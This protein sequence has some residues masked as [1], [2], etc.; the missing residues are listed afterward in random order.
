MIRW[1]PTQRRRV[2]AALSRHPVNSSRCAKAARAILPIAQQVDGTAHAR[3][4]KP[5]DGALYVQPKDLNVR[6]FHHVTVAVEAYHVD[7]LTG[8]PGH[9]QVT[10][11]EHFYENPEGHSIRPVAADEWGQL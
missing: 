3:L 6:W 11:L 7:V 5:P 1:K 2:A 8:P 4:I 10:Y 9:E